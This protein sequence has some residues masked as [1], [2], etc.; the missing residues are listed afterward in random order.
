M[1]LHFAWSYDCPSTNTSHMPPAQRPL[2][3]GDS[4]M[5]G[6]YT[7]EIETTYY[8]Q[9]VPGFPGLNIAMVYAE[10]DLS[11]KVMHPAGVDDNTILFRSVDGCV[12][13]APTRVADVLSCMC[14]YA[15]F[16]PSPLNF[17]PIGICPTKILTS[18]T[19]LSTSSTTWIIARTRGA[20]RLETAC[21]T[22]FART[23]V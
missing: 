15:H 4:K 23:T 14:D 17:E 6:V 21:R 2:P 20:T 11:V 9:P 5:E 12:F 7:N 22:N 13:M 3:K 8:Y 1:V 16:P 19:N 10:Q 18:T